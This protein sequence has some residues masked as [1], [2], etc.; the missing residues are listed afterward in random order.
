MIRKIVRIA[1]KGIPVIN[2]VVTV[3]TVIV[4][5]AKAIRTVKKMRGH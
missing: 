4:E 3:A 2:T 1:T 5:V